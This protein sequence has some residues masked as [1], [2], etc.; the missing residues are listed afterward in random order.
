MDL[1]VFWRLARLGQGAAE[2]SPCPTGRREGGHLRGAAE[3]VRGQRRERHGLAPR[4][5]GHS[6]RHHRAGRPFHPR[7]LRPP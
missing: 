7:L 2:R 1:P 6:P 4:D 5:P 3:G